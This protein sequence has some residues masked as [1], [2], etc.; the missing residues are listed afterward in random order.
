MIWEGLSAR[1]LCELLTDPKRNGGRDAQAIAAHMHTPLVLW[2]WYPGEG[3]EPVPMSEHTFLTK[4]Q[5]WT[6]AGAPCPQD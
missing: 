1:Q 4:V 6:S 3:R 2:G 5:R